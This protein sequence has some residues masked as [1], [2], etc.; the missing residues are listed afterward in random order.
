L[1]A[2]D[3][4]RRSLPAGSSSRM[5][6]LFDR[7][8]RE[9]EASL[10]TRSSEMPRPVR[11]W[12]SSTGRKAT[13]TYDPPGAGKT[14]GVGG[15]GGVGGVGV[16]GI[17]RRSSPLRER[18]SFANDDNARRSPERGGVERGGPVGASGGGGGRGA[19]PPRRRP[20]RAV[21]KQL[22]LIR[23]ATA[24]AAPPAPALKSKPRYRSPPPPSRASREGL[25]SW[26]EA[27]AAGRRGPAPA[28][29][30]PS[31]SPSPPRGR[32]GGAAAAARATSR[33]P[34]VSPARSSRAGAGWY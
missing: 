11:G 12:D 26:A 9:I 32:G 13:G 16:R 15:G 7:L 10:T 6:G 18:G 19:T 20:A 29:P 5:D 1:R 23:P 22:R 17:G 2:T 31:P 14:G 8:T 27:A 25:G 24:G 4:L 34:P 28:P 30:S 21:P 33:S 3:E